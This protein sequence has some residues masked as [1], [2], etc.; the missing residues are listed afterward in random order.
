MKPLSSKIYAIFCFI[1][2]KEVN[3]ARTC[4]GLMRDLDP[5][6][7]NSLLVMCVLLASL[8]EL[9]QRQP[10][11]RNELLRLSGWHMWLRPV[12]NFMS[13]FKIL[14]LEPGYG[15][16]LILWMTKTALKRM[17]PSLIKPPSNNLE[18][19][20]SFFSLSLCPLSMGANFRLYTGGSKKGVNQHL[21]FK[22]LFKY[23][24]LS[25]AYS[26]FPL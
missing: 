8:L 10:W 9:A 3:Q 22:S 1:L 25:K 14:A 13:N 26:D 4:H 24:I 20:A 7:Q 18:R 21:S 6:S 15:S 19:P 5:G 23:D 12:Q 11:E 17:F 16:L 2:L